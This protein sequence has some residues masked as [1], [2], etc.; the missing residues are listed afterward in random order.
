M[1]ISVTSLAL[2]AFVASAASTL[3]LQSD[4]NYFYNNNNNNM[5]WHDRCED[6]A[7][8]VDRLSAIGSQDALI[9]LKS[10]FSA[11][12]VLHLLRCC[13]SADHPSLGKFDGLLRHSVQQIT[14]WNLSETQ[15]I[16]ARLPVRDGGLGIRS[17]TSLSLPVFAASAASTL[18][19]QSDILADCILKQRFLSDILGN[20][21][22]TVWRCPRSPANQTAILGP[23]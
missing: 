20:L 19:L 17:V 21:V 2:P 5:A 13:P 9:L 4:F 12:K 18:S 8:A 11:P 1:C 14:N 6:L 15:W 7:R 23:T 10:S 16:Q 3:S 22:V